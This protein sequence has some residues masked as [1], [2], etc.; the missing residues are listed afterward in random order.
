[1]VGDCVGCELGVC[2]GAAVGAL[3]GTAECAG[4]GIAEGAGAGIAEGAGVGENVL[5]ET[6][7]TDAEDIARRRWASSCWPAVRRR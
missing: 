5:T 7:S 4:V 6:E 2:V 1:M 3:V